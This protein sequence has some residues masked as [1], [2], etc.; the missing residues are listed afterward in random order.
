MA[1]NRFE[2]LIAQANQGCGSAEHKGY[3][4]RAHWTRRHF[5]QL[6]GAGITASILS[7]KAEAADTEPQAAATPI[8]K[9]KNV[10]FVLLAGAPSHTDLFDFKYLKGT[11]PD[12][13]KPDTIKGVAWPTGILPKLGAAFGD[14]VVIRSMQSHALV[15]SLAQTWTQIG[16][17]PAAVLGDVSPNVGSL[18]AIEK[19][20]L[21]SPTNVFP[22]FLAL[23]SPGAVGSGYFPAD[24][25]PFQTTPSNT[26][27][28]NTT[29]SGGESLFNERWNLMH[30]LD[31]PLRINSPLGKPLSDMNDFYGGAKGLMYN[32]QVSKAFS[33][34]QADSVRYGSNSFGNACLVARQTLAADDGTRF[35]QITLGGWDMHQ[36]IY[37]VGGDP[38][39]GTNIFTLGKVLD[40][41]V[42]ALMADLKA[43]G[44]FD[45]TLIVI[46]GEFGRTIGPITAALGRDHYP[47]Q[48]AVF[49]GGGVKGGRTIGSTN[50]TGAYTVDPGWSGGTISGR[51]VAPEDIEATILSAVGI[52]WTK[53]RYDDPFRRGFE[54]TPQSVDVPAYPVHELW[55]A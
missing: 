15:H 54:Y 5:F 30:Q 22:T 24:Y 19:D 35:I 31:D 20:P 7:K 3:F 41:G 38:T 21:R 33:Y 34:I 39:R 8:N 26:G 48:F 42:S 55:N 40:D 2:A 53:V 43:D 18:V 17:N 27:L 11:T 10:I 32:P 13:T 46:V 14:L 36:N 9:A 12:A 47:Q 23:N 45:D 49:A 16:R 28:Q 25:A 44:T 51:N 29:H 6:A 50:D 37:G 4:S 1:R 52:D